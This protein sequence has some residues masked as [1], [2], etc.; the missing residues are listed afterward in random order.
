MFPLNPFVA[1]FGL[2][3]L[4]LGAFG[5]GGKDDSS[6]RML[7]GLCPKA[8]QFLEDGSESVL[9]N[10]SNGLTLDLISLLSL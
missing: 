7:A 1:I 4:Q 5:S 9:A 8:L 10:S 6:S 2:C 3:T